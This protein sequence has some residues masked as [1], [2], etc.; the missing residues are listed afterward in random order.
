MLG[1]M[2]TEVFKDDITNVI[3][4][5]LGDEVEQRG[6]IGHDNA[7]KAMKIADSIILDKPL[8]AI[9][10]YVKSIG[11]NFYANDK[12]IEAFQRVQHKLKSHL[13]YLND[14]FDYEEYDTTHPLPTSSWGMDLIV[15]GKIIKR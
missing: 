13:Y 3:A 14:T 12:P 6:W 10:L 8:D 11:V 4:E 5:Y 15:N 9:Y 2:S 7:E 1:A